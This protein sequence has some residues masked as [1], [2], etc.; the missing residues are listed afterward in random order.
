IG[1]S[2]KSNACKICIKSGLCPETCCSHRETCC[3]HRETCCIRR[4]TCCSHRETCCIH[5]ETC[6]KTCCSHRETCCSHRETCC[7]HR[8]TCCSHRQTSACG[9]TRGGHQ[10]PAGAT[11][12]FGNRKT[13]TRNQ[14]DVKSWGGNSVRNDYPELRSLWATQTH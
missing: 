3:S 14:K 9:D 10:D 6:C 7:I 13:C 11:S 5:R 4:E 1:K 8:E 12:A 2:Q